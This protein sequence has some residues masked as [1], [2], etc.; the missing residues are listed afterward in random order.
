MLR[1]CLLLCVCLLGVAAWA[2]EAVPAE[3]LPAGLQQLVTTPQ[4]TY[5]LYHRT[6]A[7]DTDVRVADFPR[8]LTLDS[9]VYRVR[10]RKK[11]DVAFYALRRATTTATLDEVAAFFTQALGAGVQ[12]EDVAGRTTLV[13]GT[14]DQF[15]MVTIVPA[16]GRTTVRVERVEKYTIPPRVYTPEEQ[17]VQR[18]VQELAAAYQA[19]QTLEYRANW[20]T[21]VGPKDTPAPALA[22]HVTFSRPA[23]VAGTATVIMPDDPATPA[24]TA[25][26][27]ATKGTSLL[28]TRQDGKPETRPL[29]KA[30]T[31]DDV[32]ELDDDP[33]VCLFLGDP[34][35][36][37]AVDALALLPVPGMTPAQ[38][39]QVVLTFPDDRRTLRLTIDRVA[40]RVLRSDVETRDADGHTATLRRDYLTAVPSPPPPAT[41][42]PGP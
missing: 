7:T 18:V 13:A 16:A 2:A 36:G 25:L 1:C 33:V 8:G 30:L 17:R 21:V 24:V 40:R 19:R 4:G 42:Q 23:Q 11:R 38:A 31:L 39:V 29:G 41:V 22:W 34:L 14:L 37:P 3:K 9:F 35:I 26:T 27:Y 20:I 15:R 10:D 32:A 5:W 12:R 6:P 28:V